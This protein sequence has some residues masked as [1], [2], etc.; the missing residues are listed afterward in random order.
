MESS[1]L[2]FLCAALA[3]AALL[4]SA[5]EARAI[6]LEV[7]GAAVQ[8][9]GSLLLSFR[10]ELLPRGSPVRY[11]LTSRMTATFV[12]APPS[13]PRRFAPLPRLALS[14]HVL[15]VQ[16]IRAD[17]QG[18]VEGSI[19]SDPPALPPL[20]CPIGM[21]P[22]LA[23]ARYDDISL[24]TRFGAVTAPSTTWEAFPLP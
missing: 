23:W 8:A 6:G 1:I 17:P 10:D 4:A 22:V 16:S 19:T 20:A 5:G 2:P 13:E 3:G 24:V 18:N 21:A 12:C 11:T 15:K 7:S 14:I 9:D